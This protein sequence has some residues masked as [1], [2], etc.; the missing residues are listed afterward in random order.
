MSK[1]AKAA[2]IKLLLVL[3]FGCSC[4]VQDWNTQTQIADIKAEHANV[5]QQISEKTAAAAGAARKA[6]Q[7]TSQ[8]IAAADSKFTGEFAGARR[9]GIG[10]LHNQLS[11]IFP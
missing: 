3:A 11:E 1:Q 4:V 8:A 6:E 2:L 9:S 10:F 5:L 7:L